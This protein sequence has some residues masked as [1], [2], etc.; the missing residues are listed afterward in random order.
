[1]NTLQLE[2]GVELTFNG[3]IISQSGRI[4][5]EKGEKVIIEEVFYTE[6]YWSR[7]CPDI[8]VKPKLSHFKLKGESGHWLPSAFVETS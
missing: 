8:Y 5:H 2:P 6:G 4:S 1:M 3:N 7:L